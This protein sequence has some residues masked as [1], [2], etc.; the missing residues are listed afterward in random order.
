MC[1]TN[2]ESNVAVTR[3]RLSHEENGRM[4]N[5]LGH[6]SQAAIISHSDD[7]GNN[8]LDTSLLALD[9]QRILV[10][11][12]CFHGSRGELC[13]CFWEVNLETDLRGIHLDTKLPSCDD[14]FAEILTSA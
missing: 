6:D 10:G 12:H 14:H 8:E 1:K 2:E 7:G 9:C 13:C 5:T 3:K 4:V 11:I